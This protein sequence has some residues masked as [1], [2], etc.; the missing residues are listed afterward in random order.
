VA[1]S[2]TRE[3]LRRYARLGAMRRLEELRQEEA[4]IRAEFPELFRGGR[5]SRR[6]A[7]A[8][9]SEAATPRRRRRRSTMSAAQR[10]AVSER[11][12]KYWAARRKAKSG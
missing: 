10:K 6:P 4:G 2:L 1:T 12:R 11:M 9:A 5:R 3:T 8:S 7:A